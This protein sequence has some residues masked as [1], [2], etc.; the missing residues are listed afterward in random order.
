M[1]AIAGIIHFDGAPVEPGQVEMMTTAM[2]HRGPGGIRHWVKGNVALGQCMLRT[3]PESLEEIQP[4]ANEDESLVLVMDGR[5][6]NWEELRKEL[7]GR[8]AVLRNRSDAEL[9]LRAYEILGRECLTRIDGDFAL[10]FWSSRKM[11]AFCARDRVGNKPFHYHWNGSTL[12]FASELQ[13]L[14]AV[15]AIPRR[16]NEGML[17]E[18]LAVD[19]Y[20]Q[21]ETL[22]QDIVRLPSAHW[23]EVTREGVSTHRYW[24]PDISTRLLYPAEKDY[25][26]HYRELFADTIRRQSRS[27]GVL[28]CEVSGG[29]DSSSIFAMAHHL[30]ACGQLHAPAIEGYTLDFHDDDAANELEYA[31]A[32]AKHWS[33]QINEIPPTQISLDE[34]Q[35]WMTHYLDSPQYPNGIMGLGIRKQARAHGAYVLMTGMGG[36]EWLWGDRGYYNEMLFTGQWKQLYRA[37]RADCHQSG[38]VCGTRWLLRNGLAP[39]LPEPIKSAL[40]PFARVGN[41]QIDN[42]YGWL[43]LPM[44]DLLL[45]R[46]RAALAMLDTDSVKPWQR[47]NLST[48]HSAYGI[49]ARESEE[50]LAGSVGVELRR[51]FWATKMVQFAFSCPA[52]LRLQGTTDRTLHR[53]AMTGL[54][55]EKILQRHSK[56][57]FM[58]TYRRNLAEAGNSLIRET[59]IRRSAWVR[60]ER[61]GIL[62]HHIGERGHGGWP[63][64][65]LWTLMCCDMLAKN[66]ET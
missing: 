50:R 4:L 54:L 28:A 12:Y 56:A 18:Y 46:R 45:T 23:Q 58:V 10:V 48:L 59:A 40:R 41:R 14:L 57:D 38:L 42:R 61:T 55:P 8:G 51:P 22:W 7:L 20:S 27:Q 25:V 39:A 47:G 24:Q 35:Q 60:P 63:E 49:Y 16:L 66:H 30:R 15:P 53:K 32:A 13:A 19:H 43:S 52:H 62:V 33:V 5:V 34:Y 31:R 26:E 2:A 9:V 64:V 44:R 6:D 21:D 17:A 37:W 29:L 3:T 36:D 11:L 1:S 65:L